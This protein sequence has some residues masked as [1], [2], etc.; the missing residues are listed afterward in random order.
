[1]QANLCHYRRM[2]R[3]VHSALTRSSRQFQKQANRHRVPVPSHRSGQRVWLSTKDLPLQVEAK[4]LAPRFVGP[5]K[6]ERMVNPAAVR[7]G[8]PVSLKVHPTFHVSQVKP[9][10]ESELSPPST[11]PPPPRTIDRDQAFTVWI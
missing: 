6:L 8:L 9:V 1:M 7:L 4:K 3:Q 11:P 2:W 10:L 5:Y